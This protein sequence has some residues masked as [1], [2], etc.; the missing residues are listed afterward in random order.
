[1][2][3]SATIKIHNYRR[4]HEGHHFIPMAMVV[5]NTPRHFIKECVCLFHNRR[6]GGH[7]SLYFCIQFFKQCIS[8]ILQCALA[9]TIENWLHSWE[10]FILNLL[11]LLDFTICMQETLEGLWGEIASYHKRDY[12]SPFLGSCRVRVILTHPQVPC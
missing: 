1:M 3:F 12:L 11:L 10:M 4:L 6:S 9:S 2:K 7:F 5:H 8:I